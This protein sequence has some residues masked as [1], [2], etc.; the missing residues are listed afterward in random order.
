VSEIVRSLELAQAIDELVDAFP[1]RVEAD[2][3]G[4]N[5]TIVKIVGVELSDRWSPRRGDLSFLIPYHYPDAA[6]YPYYVTGAS[7]TAGLVTGLQPVEWRGAP[8]TQVS[9]RH[10]GWNPSVDTALGAVVQTQSWLRTQ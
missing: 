4:A 10:N 1:G 6:I 5:G 3:D 7:P 9:L 8:A 2:D